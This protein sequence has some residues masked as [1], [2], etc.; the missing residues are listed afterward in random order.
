[1]ILDF[2]KARLKKA[3]ERRQEKEITG[4]AV[5]KLS[6]NERASAAKALLDNPVFRQIFIDIELNVIELWKKTNNNDIDA[7]EQLW[8]S[9][10]ILRK[11]EG[12]FKD[13]IMTHLINEKKYHDELNY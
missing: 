9:L 3:K 7:R 5:G 10:K 8:L 6:I 1:M 12:Q 11:I 2:I 4:E 13:D